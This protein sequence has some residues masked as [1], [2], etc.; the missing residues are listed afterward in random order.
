MVPAQPLAWHEHRKQGEDAQRD[1]LLED[2][3]L[4]GA[5][6]PVGDAVGGH[7]EEVL[8]EGDAPAQEDDEQQRKAPFGQ[9]LEMAVPGEGHEDVG[10]GK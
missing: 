7:L 6:L 8:E 2:A 4:R 5:E 3:Q 1:D 9:E 10:D